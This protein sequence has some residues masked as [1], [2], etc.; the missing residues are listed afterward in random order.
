MTVVMLVKSQKIAKMYLK[1]CK[2]N[3]TSVTLYTVEAVRARALQL[4]HIQYNH[5]YILYICVV[6]INIITSNIYIL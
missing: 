3:K 5:I 4:E 1:V 2:G 6:Y